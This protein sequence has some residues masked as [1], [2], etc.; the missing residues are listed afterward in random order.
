LQINPS[1]LIRLSPSGK[2][3]SIDQLLQLF[4]CQPINQTVSLE[5][6][7]CPTCLVIQTPIC[8]GHCVTKVQ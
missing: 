3:I 6:E 4:P 7:G 5:K 2:P 8:P 1:L